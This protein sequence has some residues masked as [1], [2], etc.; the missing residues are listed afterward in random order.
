MG[1]SLVT[2][3][4]SEPVSRTEAKAHLR[5]D[6]TSDD[7]LIDALIV[8]ARQYVEEE[9]N[10]AL[11]TQ[12][13]DWFLDDFPPPNGT[14]K[15]VTDLLNLY[16]YDYPRFS[17]IELPKPPLQSITWVKYAH[18]TTGAMTALVNATDYEYETA[19]ERGRLCPVYAKQWPTVKTQLNA[20][21]I[22]FICGWTDTGA[23]LIPKALKHAMLLLIGA[24]YEHRE[25]IVMGKDVR[26]LPVPFT[27]KALCHQHMSWRAA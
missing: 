6:H 17:I 21:N 22:R 25:A 23:S 4:A 13:W 19:S 3:P 24:Y 7:T 8:L 15:Q 16:G 9:T 1:L 10:R 11:F 18:P 26:E 5:V 12:T 20:V 2:A 14:E 27:V